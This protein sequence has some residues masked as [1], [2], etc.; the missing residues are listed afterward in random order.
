VTQEGLPVQ[1]DNQRIAKAA[2]TVMAALLL[3]S[4]VTWWV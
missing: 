2:G 3:S 4:S 1:T